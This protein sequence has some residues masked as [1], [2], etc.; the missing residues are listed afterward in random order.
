MIELSLYL[1]TVGILITIIALF[2]AYYLRE[3]RT[4]ETISKMKKENNALITEKADSER[5][6]L[7]LQETQDNHEKYI[8]ECN[9]KINMISKFFFNRNMGSLRLR[10]NG[11]KHYCTACLL[12]F[13]ETELHAKRNS[14]EC[15]KCGAEY[16]NR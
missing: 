9:A 4:K 8:S 1:W 15:P 7:K 5:I 13:R 14:F 16:H 11:G 6:I 12:E 10:N 2:L 3:P